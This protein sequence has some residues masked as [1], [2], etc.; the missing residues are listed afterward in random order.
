MG[1]AATNI[2]LQPQIASTVSLSDKILSI[3]A[4]DLRAPIGTIKMINEIIESKKDKIGDPEIVRLFEMVNNTTDQAFH[5]LENLL[6]WS[7]SINGTTTVR[8]SQLNITDVVRQVIALFTSIS[9]AKDIKIVY[10]TKTPIIVFTDEDMV[11]TI[12]RN[13]L[14]NAVKFTHPQGAIQVEVKQLKGTIDIV[15]KDSGVGMDSA[16]QKRIKEQRNYTSYMGTHNERGSGLGLILCYEFADL[17]DGKLWF[18]STLN[19]GTLFHLTLP[20]D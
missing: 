8:K 14:S 20:I 9:Q 15:V 7:R 5:L 4:H 2:S 10:K 19:K 11:R 3:I 18:T 13:L 1:T 16:T 12:V 17:L 6:R